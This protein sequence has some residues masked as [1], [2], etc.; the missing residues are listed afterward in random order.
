M[1][2]PHVVE[3][4]TALTARISRFDMLL[5]RVEDLKDE[6]GNL[7]NDL[8]GVAVRLDKRVDELEGWHRDEQTETKLRL[9]ERTRQLR[10]WQ[11]VS[12]AVGSVGGLVGSAG[13]VYA[14]G[15]GLGWW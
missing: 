2:T 11:I 10:R 4:S 15:H 1:Q 8:A 14:L 7:R 5:D 6:L 12:L 3:V 9:G 13:G